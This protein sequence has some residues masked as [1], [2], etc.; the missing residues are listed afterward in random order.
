MSGAVVTEL[1][2]GLGNQMFQYAFGRTLALRTGGELVFDTRA[3]GRD[4]QRAYALGGFR[5]AGRIAGASE[6]PMAWGR[7]TR[8]AP[9]LS[10]LGGGPR[11][12]AERGFAYDTAVL[13]LAPP[14]A[15]HGNWQSERYFADI[16]PTIRAD[17]TLTELL[18]AG[19]Q[20]LA[21]EI[22]AAPQ[23]VSVH[24]RRGDYVTNPTA[25]AYHGTCEPAWYAAA[26]VRLEESLAGARY[27]V[28]SDDVAWA[29]ANLPDFAEARFVEPAAD[30]RDE[31]D[32]HLMSLCRH[33]I[34]ANSSF[35]WWGA[36][37][38]PRP[39]KRVIAPARWFAGAAHDT[40][41]LI[42]T[43]WERL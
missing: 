10:R 17:F 12:V 43:A 25:N 13:K 2:G 3:L 39:D 7:V 34:I 23:S 8:R 15:L 30:G 29:R 6:L 28:F 40:R 9:W 36:W 31:C 38:D 26:K 14:L 19:R 4:P 37:L 27:I 32:M 20:A 18:D 21:D 22:A 42:P 41:D 33:H 11:L 35:S 16:A 5:V 24:V 1:T